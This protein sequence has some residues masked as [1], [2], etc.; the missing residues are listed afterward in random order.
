[1][2]L[3]LKNKATLSQS[4]LP[5]QSQALSLSGSSSFGSRL[6]S[7]LQPGLQS[8]IDGFTT[9]INKEA[10]MTEESS[11]DSTEITDNLGNSTN[12]TY[13]EELMEQLDGTNYLTSLK[14]KS[15][16]CHDLKI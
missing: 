9:T 10:E 14:P 3:N 5:R 2:S 16:Y 1:M 13:N 12:R 4:D 7:L 6:P 11:N 8:Q 15:S